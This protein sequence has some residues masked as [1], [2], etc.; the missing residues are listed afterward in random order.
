[1]MGTDHDYRTRALDYV[2]HVMLVTGLTATALAKKAGLAASTTNRPLRN[3][4]HCG[5]LSLTAI[6]K[7]AKATGIDPAPFLSAD[8]EG[9]QVSGGAISDHA[10]LSVGQRIA[11]RLEALGKNASA[12]ALEAGLGRSAVRDIMVHDAN[13]RIDTLKR[14]TGPLECDLAFLTGESIENGLRSDPSV[15]TLG[16]RIRAAR[17]ARDMSQEETAAAIDV[18]KQALSHWECDRNGIDFKHLIALSSVLGCQLA[19][20]LPIMPGVDQPALTDL[21]GFLHFLRAE[22]GIDVPERHFETL[23]SLTTTDGKAP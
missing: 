17:E 6:G 2:R 22:R 15:L 20:G 14:L 5:T 7:I 13:P 18:S 4:N 3:P 12:V 9:L 1:M 21:L 8:S 11:A 23:R 16:Q 10:A 19:R